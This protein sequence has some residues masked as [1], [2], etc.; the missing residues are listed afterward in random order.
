MAFSGVLGCFGSYKDLILIIIRIPYQCLVEGW[1][2]YNI[3]FMPK[4]A[5]SL[6]S[7]VRD[8]DPF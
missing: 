3:N 6:D 5:S 2:V 1:H 4:L 8:H 7:T